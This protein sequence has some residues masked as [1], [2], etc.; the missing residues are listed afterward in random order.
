MNMHVPPIDVVATTINRRRGQAWRELL[1]ST[2]KFTQAELQFQWRTD[3][4][5][6]KYDIPIEKPLSVEAIKARE[7]DEDWKNSVAD[8]V[9]YRER[10]IA[11]GALH[12][13]AMAELD[14]HRRLHDGV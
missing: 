13:A 7:A 10:M 9:Y 2:D 1:I 11:F 12:A 6:E 4:F 14:D 3:H 8:C 5:R